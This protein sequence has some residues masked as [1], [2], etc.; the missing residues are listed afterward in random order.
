M[1][2]VPRGEREKRRFLSGWFYLAFTPHILCTGV[3]RGKLSAYRDVK[4]FPNVALASLP[5]TTEQ[6]RA[7]I[8]KFKKQR[9]VF[10]ALELTV[11]WLSYLWGVGDAP[12]PLLQGHGIPSAAMAEVVLGAGGLDLTP[13][14]ADRSSCP[15]AIWQSVKW[16][17]KYHKEA[18]DQT[19]A[20]KWHIEHRLHWEAGDG[21]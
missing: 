4:A 9:A 11:H 20:G 15:E 6:I 12:N 16:W 14:L 8:E 5:V 19:L 13:G 2:S 7:E 17:H 3:Q 18:V 10:D 1:R 21:G